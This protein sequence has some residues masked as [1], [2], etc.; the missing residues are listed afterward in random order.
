MFVY[1]SLG[2]KAP[3]FSAEDESP[4]SPNS[5]EAHRD[6]VGALNIGAVHNGGRVN[7]VM[8]HPFEARA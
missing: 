8:A 6:A 2:E 4:Q 1:Q 3:H 7:G 5:K